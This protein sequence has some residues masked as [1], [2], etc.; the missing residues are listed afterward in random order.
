M[1]CHSNEHLLFEKELLQLEDRLGSVSRGA[2]QTTIE[3]FTFPHKYKKVL[4]MTRAIQ[5]K[6]QTL[7]MLFLLFRIG[8]TYLFVYDVRTEKAS[9]TKDRGGGGNRCGWEVYHMFVHARRWRGCQVGIAVWLQN[10]CNI[11]RKIFMW[12]SWNKQDINGL[13]M[14]SL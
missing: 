1:C 3:R 2:V 6:K 8:L 13:L 14:L 5:M 12:V 4:Q 7:K 11:V 9:A 10:Q